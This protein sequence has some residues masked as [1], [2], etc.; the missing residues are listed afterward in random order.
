[1][2]TCSNCGAVLV[3]AYICKC[4]EVF[5]DICWKTHENACQDEVNDYLENLVKEISIPEEDVRFIFGTC[6]MCNEISD[7]HPRI[8]EKDW[9]FCWDHWKI[10]R[11]IIDRHDSLERENKLLRKGNKTVTDVVD[12][13]KLWTN[14]CGKLDNALYDAEEVITVVRRELKDLDT[15][16]AKAVVNV[17]DVVMPYKFKGGRI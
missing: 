11:P 6:D 1:M 5:C 14:K 9:N 12:I 15:D 17:L 7:W 8:G 2:T 10:I 16:F 4:N 13:L 3:P